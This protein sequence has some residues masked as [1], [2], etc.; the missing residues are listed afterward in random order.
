MNPNP[1]SGGDANNTPG[2]RMGAAHRG[3]MSE[4]YPF[5]RKGRSIFS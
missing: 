1:D 2:Q 3:W 4:N 5:L